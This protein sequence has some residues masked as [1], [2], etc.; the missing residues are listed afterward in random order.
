MPH[1]FDPW[2]HQPLC[3]LNKS[4]PPLR[5][6]PPP[7]PPD[8]P[9]SQHA[10]PQSAH[11]HI[12]K[13]TPPR[14]SAIATSSLGVFHSI[15]PMRPFPHQSTKYSTNFRTQL[16]KLKLSYST[17]L[18]PRNL[19]H[20][21]STPPTTTIDV[22]SPAKPIPSERDTQVQNAKPTK[23][24]RA[25]TMAGLINT[26]SWSA[27]LES[28]LSSL[29][30]LS[31]TT[32]FQTLRLIK[33]PSK[34][35]RFF[36]WA[37][38]SGFTHTHQSYFMMLEILG[39]ARNL[40][41]ARNFL[42]SIP[43]KSN[44]AVPLTDKFFNSLIRS[45]GEAGLFEESVKVFKVMK[46]MGISPSTVTFNN[47]FLIL[48]KRGR[49][50]VVFELYDEMLRTYGV[51]PDL[52]TFNVLIKGF[53]MNSSVD[54]AFR[55]FKEMEKFKCEPDLITYNTIVD[56]LCRAGK[57]S[58]ASNVVKGMLK[59]SDN[60]RPNVVTYTTLIRGYCGKQEI[61]E[62]FN[63]FREMVDSGIKPNEITFNTI[64]QGLCESQKFDMIK[65][66]LEEFQG[67][68]GGF[69][70]DTCT[71]N[72]LMN[73]L[74]NRE[75]LDEAIKIFE[76]MKKLNVERDSATYSVLIRSLC[77]K[78][79]FDKAEELLDEL[80]EREILLRDNNCTPLVAA[81][82]PIFE[83][84]CTDG[85]T[86]KAERV[87]RQLMK[88]GVQDPLAYETLILGH[89]KEGA[90]QD[91]HKLLILMLRRDFLPNVNI[92]ESLIEGLLQKREPNLAHNTLEK[93]LRSSYL[94]RTS[95]FH[96]VL[97]ELVEK[98]SAHESASLMMLMLDKDIRPNIN[99]STDVVRVLFS[100]GLQ[101]EAFKLVRSL[102]DNGYIVK[103]EELILFLCRDRKLLEA[104][105]LL[106]FTLK[107]DQSIDTAICSTVL[108]SLCKVQSLSEAF[109]LYYELL[110]KGFQQPVSCL[111]DLRNAL[112]AGGKLKE[113]EFVAKR[114]L[115]M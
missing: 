100:S 99:V 49:T 105:E 77:Q 68:G 72:T 104:C 1:D 51:K 50:G 102:Y 67:E 33:T 90:F 114:M 74:C 106:M 47:L 30:P 75:N 65:K 21:F 84:L 91:G 110:E 88:R 39:R 98:G 29:T 40:N 16:S 18:F 4:H 93:M 13:P 20:I 59:K 107:N 97:M 6:L 96:R 94:P 69:I 86:K 63:V 80:F 89:C 2:S 37:R 81:Y 27:R 115:N 61:E 28:R 85:K 92:Y 7:P 55:K 95:M 60:L 23:S 66:I 108:T 112:E 57:V 64:I 103:V 35:F 54:E 32:F 8:Q 3:Y 53:C 101:N 87:F 9:G 12:V 83:H 111:E 15:V 48:L 14:E 17:S 5:L 113:A 82:N 52:Y 41:P 24:K 11:H 31:Q 25:R 19:T 22:V 46:S 38:D 42:L 109:H 62:A 79:N 58:V 56:G 76:K 34:A 78:E 70:P 26:E 71:F 43:R 45:Y 10:P 44:N 36:K 73:A